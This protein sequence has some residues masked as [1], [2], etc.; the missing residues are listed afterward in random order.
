M[1][2]NLLGISDDG[3][4]VQKLPGGGVELAETAMTEPREAKQ[5][6]TAAEPG[7]SCAPLEGPIDS[8]SEVGVSPVGALLQATPIPTP[9]DSR[10]LQKI[11]ASVEDQLSLAKLNFGIL[12]KPQDLLHGLRQDPPRLAPR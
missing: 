10:L 6:E 1:A 12:G 9:N 5:V 3:R 4:L 7:E 8:A 2:K 11:D